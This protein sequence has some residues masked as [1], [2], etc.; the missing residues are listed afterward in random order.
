MAVALGVGVGV[1]ACRGKD[2]A[3]S[4]VREPARQEG[5]GAARR[6]TGAAGA[7][8][9]A[10]QRAE[11]AAGQP[12]EGA[13]ACAGKITEMC[14]APRTNARAKGTGEPAPAPPASAFDA[15]GCL[16]REL[17]T[18]GCCNPALTGPRFEGGKCCYEY[19]AGM[20]CGRALVVD[21]RGRTAGLR[22]TREWVDQNSV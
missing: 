22:R 6:D 11:G 16:P 2:G 7:E 19:C 12:A 9:G 1:A 13:G 10:G 4:V 21:G 20:C 17:V 8:A 5:P 14:V 3:P 18:S 15:N